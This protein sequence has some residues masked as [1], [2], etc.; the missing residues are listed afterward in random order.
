M[1]SARQ[2]ILFQKRNQIFW[3]N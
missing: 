1:A 3:L 2:L